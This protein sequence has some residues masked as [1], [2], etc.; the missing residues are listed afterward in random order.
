MLSLPAIALW[1]LQVLAVPEAVHPEL[2][3]RHIFDTGT[4]GTAIRLVRDPTDDTLY[5]LND[6]GGVYR[7]RFLRQALRAAIAFTPRAIPGSRCPEV[8][9][10]AVTGL[11]T[12]LATRLKACSPR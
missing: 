1:S 7:L 2:S 10:S 8:L 4:G 11:F 5:Y 3:V 9:P 12:L 6:S